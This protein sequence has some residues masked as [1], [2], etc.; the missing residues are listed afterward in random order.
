MM[1][2]TFMFKISFVYLVAT[3]LQLPKHKVAVLL[4][5]Y[6]TVPVIVA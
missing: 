3:F 1:I 6:V 4:K 5:L 2:D